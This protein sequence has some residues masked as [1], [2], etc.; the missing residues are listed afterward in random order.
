MPSQ[1]LI[2]E[3]KESPKKGGLFGENKP[4]NEQV[5]KKTSFSVPPEPVKEDKPKG[6]FEP[7]IKIGQSAD[8]SK[9][10]DALA[11]KSSLFGGNADKKSETTKVSIMP[12]TPALG[13]LFGNKDSK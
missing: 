7:S 4:S 11:T 12:G 1:T 5:Q 13:S 9:A 3:A 8:G 10:T 6:L 2:T